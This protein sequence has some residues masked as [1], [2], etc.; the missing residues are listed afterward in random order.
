MAADAVVHR[1]YATCEADGHIN[2]ASVVYD[3]TSTKHIWTTIYGKITGAGTGGK[4]NYNTS[5][6]DA[7]TRVWYWKSGD[8]WGQN[9]QYVKTIPDIATWRAHYERVRMETIFDEAG[10]DD[11]CTVKWDY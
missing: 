9:E 4:S 8:T 5:I 3:L 6:Y 10:P 7:D 1:D 11:K 2:N